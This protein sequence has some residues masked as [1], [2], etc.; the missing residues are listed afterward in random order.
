MQKEALE[1]NYAFKYLWDESQAT[2]KTYGA[3]CT[4]DFYVYRNETHHKGPC[5]V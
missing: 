4:P 5:G 3:V 1:Q 2:A